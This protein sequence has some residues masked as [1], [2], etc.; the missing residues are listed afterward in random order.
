MV[1]A[2]DFENKSWTFHLPYKLG[3]LT[4]PHRDAFTVV[5]GGPSSF[6]A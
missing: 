4:P 1:N 5:Q 2:S 6:I 3:M